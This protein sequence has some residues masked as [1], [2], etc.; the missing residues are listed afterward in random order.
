MIFMQILRLLF[1]ICTA[2]IKHLVY[3]LIFEIF[4]IF[5]PSYEMTVI[6]RWKLKQRVCN[7]LAGGGGASDVY[8]GWC[9]NWQIKLSKYIFFIFRGVATL[10]FTCNHIEN[11]SVNSRSLRAFYWYLLFFFT[12]KC[13]WFLILTV[14]KYRAKTN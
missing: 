6:L 7:F 14:L 9:A 1:A 12:W 10:K 11:L 2:P 3:P 8:F 13:S 4:V 5:P